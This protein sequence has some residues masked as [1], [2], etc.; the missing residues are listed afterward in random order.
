MLDRVLRGNHEKRPRNFAR[1]PLHGDLALIHYFEQ[2]RLR[3]GRSAV[4]FICQQ[5]ISEDGAGLEVEALL[6]SGIDR[7]TEQI[8]GE[9]VAGE[10]DA[11]KS[12]IQRTGE[13][14]SQSGLSHARNA[15]NQQMP[16]SEH[17]HQSETNHF[18]ASAD[19]ASNSALQ[20]LSALM[21]GSDL[22][23]QEATHLCVIVPSLN[24]IPKKVLTVSNPIVQ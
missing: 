13:R 8:A 11:L 6:G 16:A 24:A 21:Q 3:L 19:D 23:L 10:L 4:N 9:H 14:L 17:R 2:R 22:I 7:G 20:T 12:A 5:N 1:L 18:I 15:F